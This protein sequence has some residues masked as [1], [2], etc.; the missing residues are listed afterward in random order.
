MCHVA[1]QKRRLT[2]PELFFTQRK[3]EK[4]WRRKEGKGRKSS[5]SGKNRL[6]LKEV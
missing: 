4:L 1:R 6:I 5:S 3:G 2:T